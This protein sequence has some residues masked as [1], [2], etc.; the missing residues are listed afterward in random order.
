MIGLAILWVGLL[1]LPLRDDP[2]P[3]V[4][5]CDDGAPAWSDRGSPNWDCELHGCTP[6]EAICWSERLDHCYDVSGNDLG[7]C[8][9]AVET[10]NS[11]FT[12]FDLWLYC[13]GQY[14]CTD[15]DSWIGCTEGK[16]TTADSPAPGTSVG[17]GDRRASGRPGEPEQPARRVSGPPARESLDFA[18]A[19]REFIITAEVEREFA[20]VLR[21][22]ALN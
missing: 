19:W 12:C 18:R 20:R 3:P 5:R 7:L 2:T 4:R 15:E 16:C 10:C 9:F 6:H 1:M 21:V 11:R 22:F 8:L 13:P 17:V 14:E